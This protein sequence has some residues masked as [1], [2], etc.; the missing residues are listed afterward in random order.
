M[1][2][3]IMFG[4]SFVERYFPKGINLIQLQRQR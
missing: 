3:L 2:F 1:G 4:I